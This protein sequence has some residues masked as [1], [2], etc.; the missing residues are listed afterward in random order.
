MWLLYRNQPNNL[1]K[2]IDWF[3]YEG[4]TGTSWGKISSLNLMVIL[5]IFLNEKNM[6]PTE[7]N[8]QV[9]KLY[10]QPNCILDDFWRTLKKPWWRPANLSKSVLAQNI[11]VRVFQNFHCKG[12]M[13]KI[14]WVNRVNLL[15][16]VRGILIGWLVIFSY[17]CRCGFSIMTA[18]HNINLFNPLSANPS[19]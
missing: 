15:E 14:K 16:V 10:N 3:L 1:C 13:S 4:N 19:Q 2:S 9:S 5:C 8:N 11:F 7:K 12:W 17:T 18:L 6:C